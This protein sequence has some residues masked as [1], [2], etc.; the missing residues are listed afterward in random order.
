MLFLALS[1]SPS[2]TT[3]RED[4]VCL[5]DYCDVMRCDVLLRKRRRKNKFKVWPSSGNNNEDAET[6]GEGGEQS[7]NASYM[8]ALEQRCRFVI[9]QCTLGLLTDSLS[10]KDFQDIEDEFIGS[11]C[12]YLTC[13]KFSE[14][15]FNEVSG[16]H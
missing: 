12:S 11:I 6:E 4:L 1:P 5:A 15:A 3:Q 8:N 14:E 2:L 16:T 13:D 9:R 10:L 7:C